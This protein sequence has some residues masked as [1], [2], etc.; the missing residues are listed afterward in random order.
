ML[1][2]GSIDRNPGELFT[3]RRLRQGLQPVADAGYVVL[4]DTPP[5][6][7]SAEAMTLTAA[8]DTTLLVARARTSRWRAIQKL[9]EGLRREG[10]EV[11]GMVLLG[12]RTSF[13]TRSMRRRHGLG[14]IGRHQAGGPPEPEVRRRRGSPAAGL[15]AARASGSTGPR[16][17]PPSAFPG[18][19]ARPP[20]NRTPCQRSTAPSGTTGCGDG[21]DQVASHV[22]GRRPIGGTVIARDA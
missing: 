16:W 1:P 17:T 18:G 9:A 6:L 5:T 3:T 14:Y 12:D 13:V 7:W 11:A 21:P 8:A 19:S 10:M 4:I 20:T 22:P 15:V 2:A